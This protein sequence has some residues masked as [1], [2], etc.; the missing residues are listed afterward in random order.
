MHLHINECPRFAVIDFDIDKNLSKSKCKEIGE[1]IISKLSDDII[2][3]SGSGGLHVYVNND[4]I[5]EGDESY[6]NKYIKCYKGDGFEIDYITSIHKY[7]ESY[8][9]LPRT[10]S[11]SGEY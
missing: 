10:V 9:T 5:N 11:K 6:D 4:L 8:I 7:K 2:V 1:S 3:I